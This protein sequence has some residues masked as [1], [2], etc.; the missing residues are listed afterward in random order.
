MIF[1]PLS[2][3]SFGIAFG[4][5]ILFSLQQ[6]YEPLLRLL[7]SQSTK[8]LALWLLVTNLV[9]V[10]T[11]LALSVLVPRPKVIWYNLIYV[12]IASLLSVIASNVAFIYLA[13][14]DRQFQIGQPSDILGVVAILVGASLFSAW[15]IETLAKQ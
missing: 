11:M 9:G 6:D 15:R 2:F 7:D 3:V 5:I 14:G 13:E 10:L 1:L 8:A 4:I 12:W